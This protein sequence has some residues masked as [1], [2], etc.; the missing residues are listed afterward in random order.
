MVRQR[1]VRARFTLS[2]NQLTCSGCL[3]VAQPALTSNLGSRGEVRLSRTETQ[4]L[5]NMSL[6]FIRI[7]DPI[8]ITYMS[9]RRGYSQRVVD[10]AEITAANWE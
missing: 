8:L 6:L 7:D 5:L 4:A 3:F 9:L 2:A 1:V 10:L